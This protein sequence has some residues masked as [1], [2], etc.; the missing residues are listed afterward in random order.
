NERGGRQTGNRSIQNERSLEIWRR[1]HRA[2]SGSRC[3]DRINAERAPMKNSETAAQGGLAVS[4]NIPSEPESR[5]Q[6]NARSVKQIRVILL[7][8]GVGQASR[9]IGRGIEGALPDV[10]V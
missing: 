5:I 8:P 4:E 2:D 9:R 6:L 7:Y 3:A 1:R 10:R